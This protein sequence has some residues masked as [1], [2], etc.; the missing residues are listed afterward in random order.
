ME[1]SLS[2]NQFEDFL[3]FL[4]VETLRSESLVLTPDVF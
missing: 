1:L 4:G 2:S 3:V